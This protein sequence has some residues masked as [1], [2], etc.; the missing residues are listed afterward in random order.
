MVQYMLFATLFSVF[1]Q[2]TV[3]LFFSIK[4]IT[5]SGKVSYSAN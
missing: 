4:F 1:E 3:A 2:R 5:G